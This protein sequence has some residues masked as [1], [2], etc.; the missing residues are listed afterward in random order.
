MC[1]NKHFWMFDYNIEKI[2]DCHTRNHGFRFVI[3]IKPPDILFCISG[4]L[5]FAYINLWSVRSLCSAT[6]Y[7]SSAASSAAGSR[8]FMLRLIFFSSPLK[9]TTFAVITWPTLR[10]SEGFSTCSQ[11]IWD[12]CRRA[13]T[14]GSSSTNAPKSVIRAIVPSTTFPTAY[15]SSAFSHGFWSSNFRL[16]AILSPWISLIRTLIGSPTLKIF[17]GFSTLPQDISEICSRPSAPPR[18][19]N[20]PKSVTFLTTPSTTSPTAIFSNRAFCCSA[21]AASN[22][23]FLSPMILL[24]LGLNSVITNSIS[25]S[26]YLLRSFS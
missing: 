22:S 8:A 10:T 21:F 14:P 24:L 20:A 11:E 3:C 19:M 26:A 1:Y 12:T 7:S 25:W 2:R 16:S 13:S 6:N 5:S 17:F 9:S 15:F 18:S 23:C 4:G